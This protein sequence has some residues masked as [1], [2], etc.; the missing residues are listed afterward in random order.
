MSH[1]KRPRDPNQLAKSIIDI[2]TGERPD[3]PPNDKDPAAVRHEAMPA[4]PISIIGFPPEDV[5][6]FDEQ[7]FQELSAEWRSATKT[8]TDK[9]RQLK[10][11]AN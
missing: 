10:R 7:I 6:A 8:S 4:K 3:T 2:A 9:W 1:P 11:A 5:F